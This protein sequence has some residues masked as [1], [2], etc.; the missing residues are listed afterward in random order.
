MDFKAECI[1]GEH[2]DSYGMHLAAQAELPAQL[3]LETQPPSE[4]Q[5][6]PQ[7]EQPLQQETQQ[8]WQQHPQQQQQFLHLLR[9]GSSDT[10]TEVWRARTTWSR[11]KQQGSTPSSSMPAEAAHSGNGSSVTSSS[12]KS[13]SDSGSA[14]ADA[15]AAPLVGNGHG[16][17]LAA[18]VGTGIG[19][20]PQPWA[21]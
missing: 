4:E 12:S 11:Q 14:G 16:S 21:N 15:G 2:V 18:T 20:K 17:I 6:Q 1:A 8:P 13:S 3:P 5:Q 7:P 10:E 9:K 19:K